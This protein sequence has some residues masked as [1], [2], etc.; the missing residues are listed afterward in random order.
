MRKRVKPLRTRFDGG[1]RRYSA[2]CGTII[3]ANLRAVASRRRGHFSEKGG[4]ATDGDPPMDRP[5]SG[6]RGYLSPLADS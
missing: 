5:P 4:T 1:T 2:V 6:I 3:R